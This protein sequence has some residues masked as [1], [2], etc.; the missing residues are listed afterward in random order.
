MRRSWDDCQEGRER[1]TFSQ[2]VDQ[3]NRPRLDPQWRRFLILGILIA[4]AFAARTYQLEAQSLWWDET[5]SFHRA[6]RD[7]PYILSGRITLFDRITTDQHPPLYFLILHFALSVLGSSEFALRLPSAILSVLTVPLSYVLGRRLV[8]EPVGLVTAFIAAV[9]PYYL[10]YGQEARPYELV[11]VLGTASGYFLARSLKTGDRR[12]LFFYLLTALALFFTQYLTIFL[13]VSEA[14]YVGIDS[15]ARRRVKKLLAMGAFVIIGIA[16]APVAQYLMNRFSLLSDSRLQAPITDVL[17]D[18]AITFTFGVTPDQMQ[19]LPYAIGV[20]LLGIAGVIA[21]SRGGNRETLVFIVARFGLPVVFFYAVSQYKI[22]YNTRYAAFLAPTFYLLLG[23]GIVWFFTQRKAIGALACVYIAAIGAFG[24]YDYFSLSGNFKGNFRDTLQYVALH[25]EPEDSIILGDYKIVTAFEYYFHGSQPL[26]PVPWTEIPAKQE[27]V[28]KEIDTIAENHKRLW[29]VRW[30]SS[31]VDPQGL[32]ESTLDSRYWRM[33][34]RVFSGREYALNVNLYSAKP[35]EVQQI[36][37]N[38]TPV[39]ATFDDRLSLEAYH[40]SQQDPSSH[41]I[42]ITLYWKSKQPKLPHYKMNGQ[43]IDAQGEAW[44]TFDGEP[45]KGFYATA[46]W[47]LGSLVADERIIEVTPGAPPGPYRLRVGV[48]N[49]NGIALNTSVGGRQ[50][51]PLLELPGPELEATRVDLGLEQLPLAQSY[52]ADFADRVLLIGGDL[53][54]KD[55]KA[56]ETLK[57]RLFWQAK[58]M[59]SENL[60]VMLTITDPSGQEDL[61]TE[62]PISTLYPSAS[63]QPGELVGATYRAVI[64][65]RTTGGTH[66]LNLSLY[67]PDNQSPLNVQRGRDVFRAKNL[68]LGTLEV[69]GIERHFDTPQ[70]EHPLNIDLTDIKAVGFTTNPAAGEGLPVGGQEAAS[71]ILSVPQ[72]EP[73]G[74]TIFWQPLKDITQEY[75]VFVQLLDSNGKLVVQHDGIP[76]GGA[77]MTRTWV[78][79]EVIE[80]HHELTDLNQ[81]QPG[82]YFL[83]AGLYEASTQKRMRLADDKGD[84]F[85]L[86]EVIF[87]R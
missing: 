64:P 56:G 47:K 17:R 81:I 23:I 82:S 36:P 57:F 14:V 68:Q 32:T 49:S 65:P 51:T 7:I 20:L 61:L 73:L 85:A 45:F 16:I 80:D 62:Q 27:S 22:V 28:N 12:F 77:R 6:V 50:A 19:V 37:P 8:S 4:L 67:Q 3:T 60:K 75:K 21:C 71:L 70:L 15:L 35:Y 18:L 66:S 63:W 41:R 84:Y 54:H 38:A 59:L 58:K 5:L 53:G 44:G 13:L 29:F 87:Q 31:D 69:Q 74:I 55:V 83:I 46:D 34:E 10:Y 40:I 2:N 86:S 78:A 33:D 48:R 25:A 39:D 72:T 26:F 76:Q 11:V 79:G 9:S 1:V 30:M 52:H 43:L 42:K 24:V